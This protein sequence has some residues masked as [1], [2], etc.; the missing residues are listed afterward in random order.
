LEDA[1]STPYERQNAAEAL[2][3][4]PRSSDTAHQVHQVA[5]VRDVT[6]PRPTE[7]ATTAGWDAATRV[8]FPVT[9]DIVLDAP[10]GIVSDED[11]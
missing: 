10:K 3:L 4:V 6:R 8:V 11:E 1:M 9:Y 5:A 7:V 2:D